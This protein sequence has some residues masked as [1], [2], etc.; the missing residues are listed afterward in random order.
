MARYPQ[1]VLFVLPVP[2]E[3][4]HKAMATMKKCM[5]NAGYLEH[6]QSENLRFITESEAAAIYIMKTLNEHH[7]SVGCKYAFII[8]IIYYYCTTMTQELVFHISFI[9]NR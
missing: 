4:S 9:L 6:R 1:Q 7:L 2:D 3:W 5:Y 8:Y